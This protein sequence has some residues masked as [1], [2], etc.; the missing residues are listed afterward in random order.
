[1]GMDAKASIFYGYYEPFEIDDYDEFYENT[2]KKLDSL[3]ISLAKSGERNYLGITESIQNFDWD[4]SPQK[5][6]LEKFEFG[7]NSKDWNNKLKLACGV[8]GLQFNDDKCD[9]YVTCDYR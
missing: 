4:Y 7:S 8:V 9:W 6:D 5:L 2:Q 1:M 3:E